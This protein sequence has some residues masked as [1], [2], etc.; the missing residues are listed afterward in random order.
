MSR[1]GDFSLSPLNA[2]ELDAVKTRLAAATGR[3]D[4]VE[5]VYPLSPVQE[6]ML[7]QALASDVDDLYIVQQRLAIDGPLDVAVFERAW[8]FSIDRHPALRTVFF[9]DHEGPPAQVVCRTVE[10]DIEVVDVSAAANSAA[11]IEER[12]VEDRGNRFGFATPPLM[13]LVLFRLA[14]DRHELLWS[15][16]HLLEDGWSASNVL[17]EVFDTYEALAAGRSPEPA[18]ARPYREY[19]EWLVSLDE[20]SS[21]DFWRQQFAGFIEPTAVTTP[22]EAGVRRYVRLAK[23]LDRAL[24]DGVREFAR[25]AQLTLN[26]VLTGALAIVLGRY[27]DRDDVAFGVVA[28]GRLATLRDVEL[29]VGMFINT[30]VLRTHIEDRSNVRAWLTALQL[31]QAEIIEHEHT[32]LPDVQAWSALEPGVPLTDTLFAYWNFDAADEAPDRVVRYRTIEGY[33][34]TGFPLSMTIEGSDPLRIALDFDAADL[35][36]DMGR[37]MLDHFAQILAA[38]ITDPGAQVGELEMLTASEYEALARYNDTTQPLRHATV[39]EAFRSQMAIDSARPAVVSG[40]DS[41]SYAELDEQSDRVA[42]FVAQRSVGGRIAIYMD[43]SADLLVAMLGVLK[44]GAAYVPIDTSYPVDRVAFLLEDAATRLV[45][46]TD[47]LIDQLPATAAEAVTL[48]RAVQA[49]DELP[50]VWIDQDTAAYVMYTSGS[51]GRPKGVIVTHGNLVN[52]VAWAA[53]SYGVGKANDFPLYSSIGFD[54]TVTSLFVP[55]VSGGQVV[56]YPDRQDGETAIGDVFA[57]DVVDVVKLTPSHLDVLGA[58]LFATERIRTLVLG[59]EELTSDAAREV[60][61]ASNHQMTILNEYGPTEATVGCMIHRFDADLDVSGGVPIG[62]PAANTRIHLLDHRL[63]P[64]PVGVAGEICIAGAGVAAGYL[65]RPE[66][67]ASRFL[68]E[69]GS[70][71]AMYRTGD[72]GRWRRPGVMEFLGR[73]DDQVKVRGHRIELGEIEAVLVSHPAVEQAAVAIRELG[74]GDLRLVAYYT[75]TQGATVTVTEVRTLLRERLPEYM[76]VQNFV[77]IDAMPLTPHGKLDRRRLP[78]GIGDTVSSTEF[79]TPTTPTEVL[80]AAQ[81]AQL[82]GIDR[83]SITDNFFDLGGHSLLALRLIAKLHAETGVRISPRVLLLNTLQQA[84]GLLPEL[85]ARP[86]SGVAQPM[87]AAPEVTDDERPKTVT[88]GAYYFGT[89][90][91]PLF[92]LHSSPGDAATDHAVLICPPVGWEYMRT[93]WALRKVA[94][95][96]VTS[97]LHVLRFD[98]YGTGDSA[99]DTF[100][101]SVERWL[102]DIATAYDELGEAA[103]PQRISLVGVR[104]GATLAALATARGLDVDQLV[105]WDPVVVGSRHLAS[106]ERMH[107]EMLAGRKRSYDPADL[108]SE[109]LGFP[110]TARLRSGL[111]DLDLRRLGSVAAAGTLLASEA[112]AEYG[113][114][115]DRCQSWMRY[116]VVSDVG[117]WDDLAS[118]QSALLPTAIPSHISKLLGGIG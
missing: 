34:R 57:D 10:V 98:Y 89:G 2:A 4:V 108:G 104:L 49:A 20:R 75:A 42:A 39:L 47:S 65:N 113:E 9:W 12:V 50:F 105:M 14:D 96:L 117:A 77:A 95:L 93:H 66:E 106:L 99:G 91:T 74:P 45:I 80:V 63:R 46:T 23:T 56:V 81:A 90:Q 107:N 110:Y 92:G 7:F 115:S 32:P 116:E 13:R 102:E 41:L 101:V 62:T 78:A 6:A 1:S 86:V 58:E 111:A 21:E 60:A 53:E 103:S 59:G 84:A 30:L 85:P 69:P 73:T 26:T 76:V 64:V 24:S 97:G 31:R 54:L 100:E 5:D 8:Q 71:A 11:A 25:S 35:D 88:T 83:V 29:M 61:R 94:R 40:D 112:R 22:D 38:M 27:T 82:L 109:L 52:Y 118:S 17:R 87:A 16:H 43:R 72:L 55:L 33:G 68:I 44:A 67:T 36:E 18:P 114:L 79:V 28:A 70:G 48:R 3:P 15:Q 19:I 51:T 37:R